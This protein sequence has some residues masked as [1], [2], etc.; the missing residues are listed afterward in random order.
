MFSL[1]DG[2]VATFQFA[3]AYTYGSQGWQLRQVWV[4]ERSASEAR[5][6]AHWWEVQRKQQLAWQL[7]SQLS[8]E[9]RAGRGSS[10]G[11]VLS[12]LS[13]IPQDM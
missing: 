13:R 12:R 6:Q 3:E 11:A 5:R 10:A 8:A 9:E 1:R 2:G 7:E 4:Q